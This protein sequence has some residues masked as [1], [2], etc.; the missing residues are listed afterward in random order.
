[1]FVDEQ[2]LPVLSRTCALAWQRRGDTWAQVGALILVT[3]ISAPGGHPAL[4]AVQIGATIL[5]ALVAWMLGCLPGARR[6]RNALLTAVAALDV[7]ATAA[8][9]PTLT[10][11]CVR[12]PRSCSVLGW[13][14]GHRT[15][16]TP[17]GPTR[18]WPAA[19]IDS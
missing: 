8:G 2:W 19:Q 11:V 18:F 9:S 12:S 17:T 15:P 5:A 3:V 13:A 7:V 16:P 14:C 4:T 1:M 10:Q 6:A